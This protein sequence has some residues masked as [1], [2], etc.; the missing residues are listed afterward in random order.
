MCSSYVIL[1]I[2]TDDDISQVKSSQVKSSQVM[3]I[4]I[5][6]NVKMVLRYSRKEKICEYSTVQFSKCDDCIAKNVLLLCHI[7]N[8][9]I[10][11]VKSY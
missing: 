1:I 5:T 11:R 9:N 6:Q 8:D 4:Y 10:S 7:I 3:G 2:C